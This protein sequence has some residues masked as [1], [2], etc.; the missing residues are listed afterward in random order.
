MKVRL[1]GLEK[2][3][4]K[5]FDRPHCYIIV[6]FSLLFWFILF[7]LIKIWGSFSYPNPYELFI[8]RTLFGEDKITKHPKNY[9][10]FCKIYTKYEKSAHFFHNIYLLLCSVTVSDSLRPH[11][12]QHTRLSCPPLSLGASPDSCPLSQWCHPTYI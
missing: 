1:T 11:G 7:C 4:R 2:G 6:F 9:Y 10:T 12:L 5:L 8:L 3:T